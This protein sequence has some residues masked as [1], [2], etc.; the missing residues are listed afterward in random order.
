MAWAEQQAAQRRASRAS[1]GEEFSYS[2]KSGGSFD[3][4]GVFG[5][6]GLQLEVGLTT[7][8]EST[9][10]QVGALA[11]K[12]DG[13]EFEPVRGDRLTRASNSKRYVVDR[14]VPD[15]EG[16]FAAFLKETS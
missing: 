7:Q 15:G 9:A 8:V 14:V 2:P 3:A 16:D 10:P 12:S 1:F 13:V 6:P 5:A 11:R 4:I